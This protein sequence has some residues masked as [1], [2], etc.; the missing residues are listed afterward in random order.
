MVGWLVVDWLVIVQLSV[1]WS[2]GWLVAVCMWS[3]VVIVVVVLVLLLTLW[4]C[5]TSTVTPKTIG[6]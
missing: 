6:F 3:V 5:L 2:V 1:V 4:F